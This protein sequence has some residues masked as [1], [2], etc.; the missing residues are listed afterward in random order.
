MGL[1]KLKSYFSL[2]RQSFK[3]NKRVYF[4]QNKTVER[5]GNKM[6]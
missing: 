5:G 2:T 3:T 4:T 1:M 6:S